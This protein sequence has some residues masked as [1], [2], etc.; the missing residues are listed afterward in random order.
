MSACGS[1]SGASS[2]SDAKAVTGGSLTIAIND[3]PGNLDPQRS[4]NG[5]NLLM[6][7]FG[8]DTPVTLLD[9]GEPAPQVVTSWKASSKAYVLTVRKG[10]TCSDGSPMNAATVAENID[11]VANPKS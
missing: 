8:Y 10:V 9:S 1:T 2:T 5:P 3:D 11:Y 6:S 7:I 4:V